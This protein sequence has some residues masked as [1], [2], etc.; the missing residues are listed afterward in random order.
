MNIYEK[1]SSA[2][3]ELQGMNIKQS[4]NEQVCRVFILRIK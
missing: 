1:L 2:R 3:L 4:G